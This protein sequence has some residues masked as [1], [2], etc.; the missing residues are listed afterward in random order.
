MLFFDVGNCF[1][2]FDL[3]CGACSTLGRGREEKSRLDGGAGK[4]AKAGGGGC[5]QVGVIPV[6]IK[7]MQGRCKVGAVVEF[8]EDLLAAAKQ[9][10]DQDMLGIWE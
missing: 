5:V 1:F 3:R 10:D 4:W 7:A 8:A 9:V 6:W 2:V